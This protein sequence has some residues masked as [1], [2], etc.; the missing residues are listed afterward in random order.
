MSNA[1]TRAEPDYLITETDPMMLNDAGRAVEQAYR[2]AEQ[3]YD[4]L[5]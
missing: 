2:A 5:Q 4:S 1:N 3:A